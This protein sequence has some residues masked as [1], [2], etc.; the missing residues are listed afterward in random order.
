MLDVQQDEAWRDEGSGPKGRRGA[1]E[2]PAGG[3][4]LVDLDAAVEPVEGLVAGYGR[5]W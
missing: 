2:A 1:Q 3:F 5:R 4:G